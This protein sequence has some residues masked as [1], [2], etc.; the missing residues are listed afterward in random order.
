[1]PT[2]EDSQA[3]PEVTASAD[4]GES[5]TVA[6]TAPDWTQ[7]ELV[8]ARTGETFRL[9]DFASK[10]VYV[11]PMATWCSNCRRQLR[12]ISEVV[13]QGNTNDVVFVALSVENDLPNE[14]LAQY[15]DD[16]GFDWT[17]AV[18]TPEL[19]QALITHFN[20]RSISNPP[21]TPHF[22][23]S[24]SGTVSELLT[25]FSTAEDITAKIATLRDS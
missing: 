3:T 5:M 11:E 23:I 1:M 13:A 10:V 25:G 8:N 9:A 6:Y 12:A 7:L 20:N 15:A 19:V 16:N 17:F 18:A 21:T 14:T 2:T 22:L 4:M 24:P